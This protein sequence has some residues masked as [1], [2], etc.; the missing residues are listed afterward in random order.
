MLFTDDAYFDKI[1]V[2]DEMGVAF[3][4]T[5]DADLVD[6]FKTW[7]VLDAP[8]GVPHPD[9]PER[10]RFT[11]FTVDLSNGLVEGLHFPDEFPPL[12]VGSGS[13][14]CG[15]DIDALFAGSGSSSAHQCWMAYLDPMLAIQAAMDN[16]SRTG[17]KTITTCLRSRTH[18]S[19]TG[20][21]EGLLQALLKGNVMEKIETTYSNQRPLSEVRSI[22]E[23]AELVRGI[24]NGSVVASA[25]FP[26][27]GEAIFSAQKLQETSAYLNKLQ[28]RVFKKS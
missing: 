2:S 1:C 20:T 4:F 13:K 3:A 25:P 9:I 21:I 11:F 23:V 22:P 16:D 19:E 28:A 8:K 24:S 5:G 26:G 15:D 17:G 6:Q 7:L 27:M 14:Q 10:A 12:I 18:N